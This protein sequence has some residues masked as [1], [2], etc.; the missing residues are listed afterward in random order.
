MARTTP[1]I[2]HRAV[3]PALLLAGIMLVAA[4]LR[5][6]I[7]AVGPLLEPIGAEAGLTAAQLGL[8]TAVPLL[9]FAAVSPLAHG[10]GERFG[11]HRTVLVALVLLLAGTLVR[12]LPGAAAGLWIGTFII[13]A[14]IA[15]GNVLIPAVVKREFPD[16]MTE[17]TGVFSAVMG[18]LAALGAGLAVPLSRVPL[19]GGAGGWR[20]A[21]GA[22][23]VLVLPALL[24]WWLWGRAGR[25]A[26]ST[27]SGRP[28]AFAGPAKLPG[29]GTNDDAPMAR[30]AV[31]RSAVAWQ[32][33]AYMGLQALTFY[34]LVSWLPT[35]E[36]SYGRP[37]VAAGW[38]L[39]FFQ[40]AGVVASLLAPLTLR[41]RLRRIGPVV[42][43]AGTAAAVLGLM[44]A[45][46]AMLLWVVVAGFF[47]G[48][49]LVVALSLFG[50]RT[51][52]HRQASAV[53]G[54]A[55]T[56]GYLLA[57]AG[58]PLFGLLHDQSAGWIWPLALVLAASVLQALVG[59][60]VGR[61]R[62][63]LDG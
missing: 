57:A 59:V 29:P 30:G 44:L 19:G 63:A 2:R 56:G 12:P 47:S 39:M 25:V 28:A 54:M 27:G 38:D 14:A 20:F 7:T 18:G 26:P 15:L 32:V 4:N 16:R 37:A 21:L 55:Q 5:P 53:S 23:A 31:W 1:I 10:L 9:A 46:G 60:P 41:G 34:V 40:L 3:A 52:T 6:A 24:V 51:R 62:Y 13:G 17:L 49:S 11:I 48:A 58:P 22:Y 50:L 33:T 8:L 45:P 61:D 42:P 43:A 35:V 36:Q